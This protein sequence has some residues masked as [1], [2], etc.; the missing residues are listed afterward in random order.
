[1]SEIERAS[2]EYVRS[3]ATGRLHLRVSQ[4]AAFTVCRRR[5]LAGEGIPAEGAF[6]SS[7]LICGICFPI[8]DPQHSD[9]SR[10]DVG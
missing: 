4:G 9:G 6:E 1:M 2:A 7:H 5:V 8:T 3:Q 10:N